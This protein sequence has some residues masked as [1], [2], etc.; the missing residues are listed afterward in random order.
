[1]SRRSILAFMAALLTASA[2]WAA[3]GGYKDPGTGWSEVGGNVM[4]SA[5][6][7]LYVVSDGTLYQ[8]STR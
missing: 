5:G 6:D 3:P 8:V 7:S 2:S 4:A 1:M